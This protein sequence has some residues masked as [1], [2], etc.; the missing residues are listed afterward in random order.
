MIYGRGCRGNY[1]RLAALA[2]TLPCFPKAANE[3]SMLFIG[4]LCHFVQGLILSGVGGL[5]FPQNREYVNTA[6]MVK[7][8]AKCHGKRLFC[9]PGMGWLLRLAE[10]RVG[11]VGKVFGTLTYDHSMSPVIAEDV[12]FEETIR[13]TE[14]SA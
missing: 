6:H 8:I 1:P 9:V 13:Q 12:P 5:F 7:T 3:R 10:S 2:R 4:T 11:V 14:V